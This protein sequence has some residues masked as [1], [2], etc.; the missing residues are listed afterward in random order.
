ME[1]VFGTLK[2]TALLKPSNAPE[3]LCAIPPY[4]Y[5]F[6]SKLAF[7]DQHDLVVRHTTRNAERV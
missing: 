7:G 2:L 1:S 5:R 3:C 4:L 6:T